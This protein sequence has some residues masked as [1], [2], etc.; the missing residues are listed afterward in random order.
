MRNSVNSR[1][2]TSDAQP[3]TPSTHAILNVTL[4]SPGHVTCASSPIGHSEATPALA[5][6][7][8]ATG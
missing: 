8:T 5:E 1:L 7:A 3:S 6:M 4:S 2:V